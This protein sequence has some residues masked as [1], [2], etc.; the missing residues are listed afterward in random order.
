MAGLVK[1]ILIFL[2]VYYSIRFLL[3]FLFPFFLRSFIRKTQR[4]M[5]PQNPRKQEGEVT[6]E[7]DS[8]SRK[9]STTSNVG[10]YVD[11]E[12]IDDNQKPS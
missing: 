5:N 6:I 10:E 9:K 3:R 12:E 1:S 2:V 4:N 11:F 7:K 8:A